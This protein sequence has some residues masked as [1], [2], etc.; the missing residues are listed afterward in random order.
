MKKRILFLMMLLLE[1]VCPLKA[2]RFIAKPYLQQL[3]QHS[4]VVSW[5]A[6]DATGMRGWVEYRTQ[7]GNWQKA[8]EMNHGMMAAF[9]RINAVKIT[10][11]EAGTTYQYRVAEVAIKTITDTS[12][13]YQDTIYSATAKFTTQAENQAKVSCKI[14][15]DLHDNYSYFEYMMD[16]PILPDFDFVMF[17][18]DMLNATPSELTILDNLIKP[19]IRKF[20]SEKPLYTV[21]GN[22]EVRREYAR[23][24]MEYFQIG[25]SQCGYYSFT[26]GPCFFIVLDSGEDAE[27]EDPE[28][29]FAFNAYRRK[30]QHW[31]EEQLQSSEKQQAAYTVVFMHIPTYGNTSKERHGMLEARSL[32]QPLFH[33]YGIDVLISAHTHVPGVY[34]ADSRHQYPIVIGGGN[35]TAS[36]ARDYPTMTT[37]EASRYSLDIKIYNMAGQQMYSLS[38]PNTKNLPDLKGNLTLLR[39]GDGTAALNT[40]AA[41]PVF[42]DEY[43]LQGREAIKT[44]TIPLPTET[45]GQNHRCVGVGSASTANFLSTSADGAYLLFGGYDAAIGDKP[46]GMLASAAPRV[47]AAV[48]WN[49]MVNTTTALTNAFDKNDFRMVASASATNFILSGNGG[50]LNASMGVG[51]ASVLDTMQKDV[52]CLHWVDGELW[53]STASTISNEQ[54]VAILPTSPAASDALDFAV[55]NLG[56][57]GEDKVLYWVSGLNTISK[58]SYV[59]GNWV[60]NGDYVDIA[61]PRAL[62]VRAEEDCI[63]LFVVSSTNVAAGAS[64]LTLLEDVAGWNKSFS[65]P[66]TTLLDLTGQ[67]MTLRGIAWPAQMPT[68]IPSVEGISST[69]GA[70]KIL[71]DGHIYIIRDEQTYDIFGLRIK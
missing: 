14:F 68:S 15:N 12:L 69:S 11:L 36:G 42:L 61:K 2:V 59:K 17:N 18:G 71:H 44:T 54:G 56:E 24:Y 64:K 28:N 27:D 10:N 16:H 23:R 51:V 33:Q 1:V 45:D 5:V 67:K 49:G 57:N 31:L 35:S 52:R 26:Y 43:H 63:Q 9:N 58:Y 22:H 53:Y 30:Q 47:A 25:N 55:V 13:V 66:S 40:S 65:G 37:L 39:L 4:V 48:D 50:L 29:L 70:Q 7:G 60:W 21:R 3:T 34:P 32:F 8:Y 62:L 6:D 38:L 46:V 20:A 41:L 19:S